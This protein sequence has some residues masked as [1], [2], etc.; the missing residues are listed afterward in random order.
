M[1]SLR[2]LP[3]LL[4]L[5]A[6]PALATHVAV[7]ETIAGKDIL[8]LEEKQYI[9]DVLRSEA[10]KAL[11]ADMGYT[12]MTRDNIQAMLP[13]DKSIEECEGSCLVETGKNI[14]ADYIAQAR[15]GVFGSSLTIT[16]ELYE[17]AGNKLLGSFVAKSPDI[18][19]LE[20]EIRKMANPLFVLVRGS[21]ELSS[22]SV[23]S[24]AESS[25]SETPAEEEVA[26]AE[27]Q[28]AP[29]ET[30][31]VL[32]SNDKF[33]VAEKEL[34]EDAEKMRPVAEEKPVEEPP[35]E[36]SKRFW[37]GL[38]VGATYN[39]FWDTKFGFG[40]LKSGDDYTLK[41][42]SAD[43]LLGNYWGVGVNAGIGALF[44]FN[45]YL[46]LNADVGVA[47]RQ[48][49]GRS[50]VI[51]KLFWND[52]SRSPEMAD[53]E[54]EYSEKQL[55]IDVPVLLRLMVPN[56]LYVEAGPQASFNLYSHHKSTIKGD[57]GPDTFREEGGLNVFEFDAAFG[58]GTMR[59][60]GKGMLDFNL[61][62]VLGITPLSDTDDS[63]KTW[64]GQFNIAYWFI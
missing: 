42:E 45:S 51:V 60:L 20:V 8:K 25:S 31:V 10:V 18:E 50:D 15:V 48:G 24:S 57:G 35:Q 63:P 38:F 7:L 59:H 14:S 36:S 34:T 11:P 21:A 43:G 55:N 54:I 3:L 56:V 49:K 16:V 46:G 23:T 1:K 40:N 44:L 33:A 12:I 58:I 28:T 29:P 41:V 5:S 9:T 17:T 19:Q 26:A 6:L 2:Q 53:L 52:G 47:F 37:G 39:D 64:Q 62:F 4:L 13:P 30:P 61:R 32:D 22:S 27:T